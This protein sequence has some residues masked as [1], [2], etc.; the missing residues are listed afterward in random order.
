[1]DRAL[2]DWRNIMERVWIAGRSLRAEVI[3]VLGAMLASLLSFGSIV[4]LCASASGE[5][6]AAVAKLPAA[7]AA[8]AMAAE[9]P[10]KPKSG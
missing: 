7:P 1:M 6:D 5:L 8:S 2:I 9:A 10:R 3:A 4:V